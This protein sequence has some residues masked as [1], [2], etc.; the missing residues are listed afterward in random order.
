MASPPSSYLTD[1]SSDPRGEHPI[2]SFAVS[3]VLLT[4]GF[5]VLVAAALVVGLSAALVQHLP[6]PLRPI[7]DVLDVFAYGLL[8]FDMLWF[9]LFMLS[10]AVRFRRDTWDMLAA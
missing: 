10:Q 6:A 1:V 5:I 9:S 8:G 7:G 3:A 4:L 2:R